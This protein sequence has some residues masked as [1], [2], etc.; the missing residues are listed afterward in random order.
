MKNT[1]TRFLTSTGALLIAFVA[2]QGS[3]AAQVTVYSDIN[4]EGNSR[5]FNGDVANL[6]EQ[7]FNDA[8]S[9]I[10]IPRGEQWQF[11]QD[12]NYGGSCQTLQGSIADLRNINWNDRIS[13]IRRVRGGGYGNRS[14]NPGSVGTSG[15]YPRRGSGV[16]VFTNPN[17][18][19]RSA[20]FNGDVADL[21]QYNL[22]DQITSI[23][24]PD[25]ET[26]EICQDIDFGN[27]CTTVSGNIAD[28]RRMGWNDRVSSMRRVSGSGYRNRRYNDG[29]YNDG[30]YDNDDRYNNGVG[31][32]GAYSNQRGLVFF[33]R[34]NFRGG[35]TLVT[36]NGATGAVPRAGSVQVRGGGVWRVCDNTGDCAN[37][38]RDVNDMRE[39]G[40]NG[41]ITSVREVNNRRFPFIR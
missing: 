31:T 29:R 41:R 21:R 3:A 20:S 2:L 36:S 18:G 6:T 7:G 33:D 14:Y 12:A 40:L 10:Q 24:I 26:W 19:G 16:T 13:S 1:I 38:D 11:C 35:T 4:F 9:S 34:P 23:E 17:F 30:R 22:N 5:T 32:S 8:I 39:L 27:Q 28:L 15:Y 37:V 25:G